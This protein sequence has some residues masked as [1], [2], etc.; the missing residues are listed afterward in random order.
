MAEALVFDA[1]RTPRGRG[2]ASGSLYSVKPVSLVVGLLHELQARHRS[3]GDIQVNQVRSIG[4]EDQIP[5]PTQNRVSLRDEHGPE[6]PG[7]EDQ[8]AAGQM[9]DLPLAL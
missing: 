3:G 9:Q 7:I 8:R 4:R 1:I 6:V 2:R 5:R